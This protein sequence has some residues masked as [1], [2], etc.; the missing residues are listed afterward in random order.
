MLFEDE[1]TVEIAGVEV[2]VEDNI[3]GSEIGK[4]GVRASIKRL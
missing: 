1:K 3:V 4:K 2:D